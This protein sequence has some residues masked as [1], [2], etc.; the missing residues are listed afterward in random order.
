MRVIGA[1]G[2]IYPSLKVRPTGD[3]QLD[4]MAVDLNAAGVPAPLSPDFASEAKYALY[5][6][7]H[8][9][10]VPV[11]GAM[12]T[13]PYGS[14]S[15]D[16]L[17]VQMR[18][19]L[20]LPVD[21][22]SRVGAV[23]DLSS[24][25]QLCDGYNTFLFAERSESQ[26]ILGFRRP[27][28]ELDLVDLQFDHGI[29]TVQR[30]GDGKVKL[31]L[32]EFLAV[33][34]RNVWSV[35]PYSRQMVDP[36]NSA[37]GS[38]A[39]RKLLDL[40]VHV[41]SPAN[42]GATLVWLLDDDALDSTCFGIEHAVDLEPFNAVAPVA[43]AALRS[44]CAQNDRAVMISER[45]LALRYGVELRS[46]PESAVKTDGGTRHNSAASASNEEP[47]AAFFV[48]S[49]DGP[50]S[51]FFRGRKIASF[52][53]GQWSAECGECAG[54]RKVH[55]RTDKGQDV[56]VPC[57]VCDATGTVWSEGPIVPERVFRVKFDLHGAVLD[58][59]ENAATSTLR[60]L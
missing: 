6:P 45:G 55:A 29:S 41:L 16:V 35:R 13:T 50:V 53:Y 1:D 39:G 54:E 48:V 24:A 19:P 46:R 57:P 12:T 15:E 23:P 52:Q 21:D 3:L 4:R 17:W 5:P 30:T 56:E 37:T 59:V 36:I 34:D 28:T 38:Q 49:Q 51:V 14:W 10:S 32:P 60:F 58:G 26:N 20:G 42:V 27:V 22:L 31:F 18:L 40:A 7:V 9:R 25:R 8:E 33:H 43:F 44:L 2:Q 47:R 11:F